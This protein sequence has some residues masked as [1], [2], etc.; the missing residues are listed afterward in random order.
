VQV[1]ADQNADAETIIELMAQMR[2]IDVEEISLI[3]ERK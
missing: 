3:T 1:K 2:E